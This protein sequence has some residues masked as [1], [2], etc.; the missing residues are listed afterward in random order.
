MTR[1]T[2]KNQTPS[3][4]TQVFRARVDPSCQ[5]PRM[6]Q[7]VLVMM[8]IMM[9]TERVK[10]HPFGPKRQQS[11]AERPLRRCPQRAGSASLRNEY[12]EKS[13]RQL[14][15]MIPLNVIICTEKQ[16]NKPRRI[17]SDDV[18]VSKCQPRGILM[19][20]EC[21]RLCSSIVR[22]VPSGGH[23]ARRN[24]AAAPARR[25]LLLLLLLGFR[26]G[27]DR[28]HSLPEAGKPG[29]DHL[30]HCNDFVSTTELSGRMV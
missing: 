13:K 15:C 21:L 1:P 7:S 10:T 2:P 8:I 9:I 3:K 5:T 23:T 28:V 20:S 24:V 19:I 18:G 11:A 17:Q 14:R 26:R 16:G 30:D 27:S 4:N 12:L 29:V 22:P 25:H 6:I